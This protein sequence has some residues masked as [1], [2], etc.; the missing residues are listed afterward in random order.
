MHHAGAGQ[1]L[2]NNEFVASVLATLEQL[3][4]A[5]GWSYEYSWTNLTS[6]AGAS[7]GICTHTTA[8]CCAVMCI[9][10][11]CIGTGGA[12]FCSFATPN[13]S[14]WSLLPLP[15]NQSA[16]RKLP[17]ADRKRKLDKT[18]RYVTFVTNEGDTPRIVDSLFGAAWA[19]HRRGSIPV[20]WAIDPGAK[21]LRRPRYMIVQPV[22][23]RSLFPR[24]H[25]STLSELSLVWRRP[26]F[27]S[28]RP[29][30]RCV[31]D[32]VGPLLNRLLSF[33]HL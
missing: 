17:V 14:F 21:P 1:D 5:Y 12:V 8:V 22:F 20:A 26:L 31:V 11:L 23:S 13:L 24:V 9:A 32:V 33:I 16:P 28:R 18:K 6:I 2:S 3:F 7:A 30:S 29:I 4:S 15:R 10:T 25:D 19:D 27:S